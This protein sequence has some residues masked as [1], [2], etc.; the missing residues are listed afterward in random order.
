MV[1]GF[2]FLN[3]EHKICEDYF[4]ENNREIY[5]S[6]EFLEQRNKP[7]KLFIPNYVTMQK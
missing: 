4:F 2:S 3:N 1:Q 6:L 7:L 5:F